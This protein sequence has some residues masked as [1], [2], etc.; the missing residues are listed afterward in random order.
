MTPRTGQRPLD[1][2]LFGDIILDV[3]QPDHYL[4]GIAPLARA[5]DLAIGHLEVPHTRRGTE[6]AGDIPA[7]GADP[8]H[9]AALADAGFGAVTM[10]GNHMADCGAIG[11]ADTIA[12][13]DALGIAHCG[14]GATLAEARRPARIV[15][16]GRTVALLSYNCVGPE[17]GWATPDRAGCAAVRIDTADGTPIS[18]QAQLHAIDPASLAALQAD[19]AAARATGALTIV[20]L[21]KGLTHRPG[22]LAPYERPLAQAAIDAGADAVIGHHAHVAQGIELHRGRPIF[23]GLG[24]GCVVTRALSPDQDH[25]TRADWAR[26]RQQ[27]FEFTPDPAYSLAP[28][29]PEAINGLAAWLRWEADGSLR[30][31]FAPLWFEPP[32][33]PILPGGALRQSVIAYLEDSGRRA[34]LEAISHRD[35]DGWEELDGVS[36]GRDS[37]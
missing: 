29:H 19:I 26:R 27:L 34:G 28:F 25:P 15:R 33:R 4:S 11:I 32:G 13:L 1:I 18:P 9:L 30:A 6:L 5:A 2:V 20:A 14:A 24:N 36:E 10:A 17:A 31:G 12:E 35:R 23:H 37:A 16:Q 22:T 21:H 7:P 3:D 8:A